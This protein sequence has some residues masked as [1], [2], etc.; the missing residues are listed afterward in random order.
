ML[1]VTVSESGAR[2]KAYFHSG[3]VHGDHYTDG[4]AKAGQWWGQGSEMLGL[5]GMVLSKHFCRLVDNEHPITRDRLTLR[6]KPERRAGYDFT[7]SP[8]KS[9]SV[10]ANLCDDPRLTQAVLEAVRFTLGEVEA[11]VRC[12]VRKDDANADRNTGNVIAALFAHHTARPENGSVPDP[13]EHIHAFLM[14]ATFDPVEA[15]WKAL[16]LRH[17]W[18]NAPYF[19]ALFHNELARLTQELG[20]RI[21]RRGTGW[22]IVGVPES[23]REVFSKRDAKIEEVAA[24]EGI[25]DPEEKSGLGRRTRKGKGPELSMAEL[26]ENWW[27]QLSSSDAKAVRAVKPGRPITNDMSPAVLQR[28]VARLVESVSHHVFARSSSVLENTF[29]A[30]CL[31]REPGKYSAS[32]V[33]D[34][35][36]TDALFVRDL[37]GERWVTHREVF[38]EEQ[39]LVD[40]VRKGK[41]KFAP[42]APRQK[43]PEDL[44]ADQKAAFH[45]ILNSRDRF[46][47]IEGP[48]GTGKTRLAATTVPV[49][50]GKL[51]EVLSP[52]LGDKVVMLAP[53]TQG[54]REVLR[55]EGFK[56]AT[57]VA[58]FLLDE[59]LQTQAREGWVWLDEAVQLG[60]R[61]GLRFVDLIEKLDARVICTGDG[62]QN[63]PVGRGNF[64]QLMQNHA[65]VVSH[66]MEEVLRQTGLMKS[67]A[68]SLHSGDVGLAF[69]AMKQ[70]Q[71]VHESPVEECYAAA[72][73]DYVIKLKGEKKVTGV[74]PTH[75]GCDIFSRHIR[76]EMK[77]QRMLQSPKQK[78]CYEDLRW[79]DAQKADRSNYQAGQVVEF[80]REV[81][82]YRTKV[83]YNVIGLDPIG[84]YVLVRAKGGVPEALPMKHA[85]GW[86]VYQP[87]DI[88]VAVGDYIRI[89]RSTRVFTV[90]TKGRAMFAE[91]IQLYDPDIRR[92]KKELGANSVHKVLCCMDNGDML[93]EG[94]KILPR[95][96][97]HY[98]HA[99]A[100]TVH[101]LQGLTTDDTVMAA[102][103][104][105]LGPVDRGNF[106]T[107]FTRAKNSFVVYTDSV[108]DL[109]RAAKRVD[110]SPAAL[111]LVEH[112][113]DPQI[114]NLEAEEQL[115][116][117]AE[118][119]R[120]QQSKEREYEPEL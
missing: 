75:E 76:A 19:Q 67:I 63:D 8:C 73:R 114:R 107:A 55:A 36:Q 16:Q 49:L 47:L 102:A 35:M 115:R 82:P 51:R 64:V 98:K 34:A 72:A 71:M 61:D 40:I 18:F 52:V 60:S 83:P 25:D 22:E 10:V 86:T 30:E 91:A 95:G 59:R 28:R 100:T 116:Q 68:S 81:G 104:D 56:D 108:D 65:G 21:E 15:A 2:A 112:G 31:R 23:A 27:S 93:L 90:L 120:W 54:S 32:Q 13:Q 96:F 17:T 103:K 42:T 14:N 43:T 45:H 97:C 109:E 46:I 88:E 5:K 118:Y 39:K 78:K 113:E 99:Y 119:M 29:V 77:E 74:S 117:T 58:A 9:L 87:K 48:P 44:S 24:E 111:D 50:N 53:T 79:T 70:N 62:G 94:W 85:D 33:R 37:D 66:R 101:S 92:P 84:W 89:T 105:Q 41:G 1:K 11:S 38:D 106:T 80:H 4:Q 12:R 26:L 110:R 3:L 7:F 20:Y 57:T 6:N 69:G